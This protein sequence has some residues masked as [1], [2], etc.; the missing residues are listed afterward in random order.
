MVDRV[1]L[2]DSPVYY[3]IKKRVKK[4]TGKAFKD[5][6]KAQIA[7]KITSLGIHVEPKNVRIVIDTPPESEKAF[8]F[9][10][11]PDGNPRLFCHP[12]SFT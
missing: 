1:N 6:A 2:S 4:T 9:K 5:A 12:I 7:E 11:D 3:Q 8:I 10:T